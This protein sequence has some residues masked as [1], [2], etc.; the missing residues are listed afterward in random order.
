M[1]LKQIED[2][3]RFAET[4]RHNQEYEPGPRS[5]PSRF[6]PN[7]VTKL[8]YLNGTSSSGKSSLATALQPLL[9]QPFLFFSIDTLL[10]TLPPSELKA[11]MGKA[12]YTRDLDW[13]SLF[14]GYFT[15][16]RALLDHGNLVI[17]DCPV[18]N[19]EMAAR[20]QKS[21]GDFEAIVKIRLDCPLEVLEQREKDRSDRTIG[22]ARRQFPAIHD[23][24]SYD[25]AVDTSRNCPEAG[26]QLLLA[27]LS[28][29]Q[30]A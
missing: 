17:A 12:R 25:F 21:L 20:F 8:I 27:E 16:V 28:P 15:C 11:V 4:I 2:F 10:Y 6:E 18:Y 22:L 9:P 7:A 23:F 30:K 13:N 3:K 5:S 24:L 19:Q 14:S 29:S 1:V 26:A